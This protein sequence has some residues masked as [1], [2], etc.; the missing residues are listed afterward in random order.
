MIK[1]TRAHRLNAAYC[2]GAALLL[3]AALGCLLLGLPGL[4]II[5]SAAGVMW[6]FGASVTMVLFEP[7]L[8]RWVNAED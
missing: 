2:G 7:A 5:S 1:L 4:S 8:N 6:V 3:L